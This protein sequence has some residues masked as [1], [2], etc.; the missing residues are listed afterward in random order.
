MSTWVVSQQEVER[1]LGER[2]KPF[3]NGDAEFKASL[4]A[5]DQTVADVEFEIRAGL[6]AEKI[7]HMLTSHER[8]ITQGEI[9]AY[10]M[11][12]I[13]EYHIP[14]RRYFDIV[15]F[16]Q[17][18]AACKAHN[19]RNQAGKSIAT[20]GLHEGPK[21]TNPSVQG[22]KRPLYE[23][24]FAAKQNVLIGPVRIK[25]T[26]FIVQVTQILPTTLEPLAQVGG[27]IEEKLAAVQQ[28]R[29]LAK[30]IEAWR[31]KGISR[32]DCHPSYVVQKCRQYNGPVVPEDTSGFD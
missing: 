19:E 13:K 21:R 20:I 16:L 9:S 3:S 8:K 24:I 25:H 26:Y 6:A 5:V 14:E 2:K 32:T 29:T 15:E 31:S 27:S 18:E 28:G 1:R 17:S 7:R 12:H 23:A 11:Q 22:I 4:K 30:F 10:Y